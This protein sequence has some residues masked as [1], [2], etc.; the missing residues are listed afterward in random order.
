ML[1]ILALDILAG[2][3]G[4]TKSWAFCSFFFFKKAGGSLGEDD[5]VQRGAGGKDRGFL[6]VC[7]DR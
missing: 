7:W 3:G 6:L 4:V 1:I 5:K 2:G